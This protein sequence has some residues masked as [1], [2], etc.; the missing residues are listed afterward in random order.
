MRAKWRSLRAKE[1][2]DPSGNQAKGRVRPLAPLRR[3]SCPSSVSA[4]QPTVRDSSPPRFLGD[5]RPRC[6][7]GWVSVA[8]WLLSPPSSSAVLSAHLALVSERLSSVLGPGEEDSSLG[9]SRV[10]LS[11]RAPHLEQREQEVSAGC[12]RWAVE[13]AGLRAWC[14]G[15]SCGELGLPHPG[16]APT[17]VH[18]LLLNFCR[19]RSRWC[20]RPQSL[21]LLTLWACRAEVCGPRPLLHRLR[22]GTAGHLHRHLSDSGRGPAAGQRAHLLRR[23]APALPCPRRQQSVGLRLSPGLCPSVS[24]SLS[25]SGRGP[26]VDIFL[27]EPDGGLQPRPSRQVEAGA[28]PGVV[29]GGAQRPGAESGSPWCSE[30]LP[31]VRD[32]DQ[33]HG[34]P[35]LV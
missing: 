16:S 1:H 10:Q 27:S 13:W 4:L 23:R 8:V 9:L 30:L 6:R 12:G 11:L 20:L 33:E 3:I 19:T 5:M 28:F 15:T 25:W 24:V 32:E 21:K 2:M 34:C 18:K 31:V 14:W 22:A 7:Q 35:S 29:R 26:P 17:F